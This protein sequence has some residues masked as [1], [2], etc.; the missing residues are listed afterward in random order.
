MLATLLAA[1]EGP[2]SNGYLF[3]HDMNEFYWGLAA[4]ICIVALLA[5]KVLP[6]IKGGMAGRSAK[7]AAQ[8]E[9]AE[10][11]RTAA[12]AEVATLKASLSGAS[13]E[14][15]R[16][17]ADARQ[18]AVQ[19]EADL[20][21]K[22]EADVAEAKRR[23]Q[24]EIEASKAQSLA[25]LRAEVLAMTVTATEAVVGANLDAA[26]QADLIEKY[27]QQVGAAR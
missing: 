18:R 13:E 7:I 14:S 20:K 3:P 24:V 15:T 26:T 5:W 8:L 9:Q 6:L 11:Q 17:V 10:A 19:I 21:A 12:D 22:A 23:A 27:I 16:I 4:F 25:D 2:S 1:A